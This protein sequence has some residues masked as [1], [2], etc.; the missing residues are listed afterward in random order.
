MFTKDRF[1]F[2]LVILTIIFC[3]CLIVANIIAGK[4]WA[5]PIT[6]VVLTAGVFCFPIVY[7]IDDVIPEVYGYGVARKII[8]LG[9]AANLLAVIF[10]YLAIIVAYPPYFQNQSA[11]QVVLG[12]T[13]RLLVASFAGY[14]VGTN[15]NAWVLTWIKKLTGPRWLWMRTIG[16]TIV[17]EGVDSLIFITIAFLGVLPSGAIPGMIIAQASFKVLYEAAV[18]PLTYTIINYFKRIENVD[19]FSTANFSSAD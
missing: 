10:F 9:F 1:S 17:G 16:S 12:F 15:V 11:F 5:T 2:P 8:A 4:L 18:T 19:Q 14:L 6:S 7:I 13:P 3:T